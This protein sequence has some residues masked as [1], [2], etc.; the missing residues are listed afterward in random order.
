MI[1]IKIESKYG[2]E[3]IAIQFSDWLL[4]KWKYMKDGDIIVIQ[5][6]GEKAFLS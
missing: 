5:F 1:I 4:L 3:I 6:V 2:W